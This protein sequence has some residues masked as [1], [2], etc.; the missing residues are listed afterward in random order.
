M[1]GWLGWY[2]TCL[3][4]ITQDLSK[5]PPFSSPTVT[6]QVSKDGYNQGRSFWGCPKG[7][8]DAGG[9]G[10]FKYVYMHHIC[11]ADRRAGLTFTYASPSAVRFSLSPHH[12]TYTHMCIQVGRRRAADG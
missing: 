2:V 3:C 1:G 9:C 6:P 11:A 8:A 10:F 5:A 12:H 4:S 7:R